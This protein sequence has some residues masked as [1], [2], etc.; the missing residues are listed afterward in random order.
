MVGPSRPIFERSLARQAFLSHPLLKPQRM[1]HPEYWFGHP[2]TPIR[3]VGHPSGMG[4]S[5]LPLSSDGEADVFCE[6]VPLL[7]KETRNES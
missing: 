6:S 5:D 4:V 2:P 3:E 1:G 7:G